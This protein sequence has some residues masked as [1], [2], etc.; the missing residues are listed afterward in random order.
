MPKMRVFL[1]EPS[2]QRIS[3]LPA[4]STVGRTTGQQ[5]VAG[6]QSYGMVWRVQGRGAWEVRR[7]NFQRIRNGA[8]MAQGVAVHADDIGEAVVKAHALMR[9]RQSKP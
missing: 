9:E 3:S 6:G 4:I 2:K 8:E 7:Y 1:V 5:K